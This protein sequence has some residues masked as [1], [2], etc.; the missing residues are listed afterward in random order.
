ML[1]VGPDLGRGRSLKGQ[2]GKRRNRKTPVNS[3]MYTQNSTSSDIKPTR[4]L[5]PL[6]AVGLESWLDAHQV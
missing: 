1:I 6:A 2:P 4:W 5:E 3:M